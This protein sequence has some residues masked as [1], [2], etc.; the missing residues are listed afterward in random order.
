LA[1]VN[2]GLRNYTSS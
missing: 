1:Q 2:F